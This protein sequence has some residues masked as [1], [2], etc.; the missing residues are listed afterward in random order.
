MK[1]NS[2]PNDIKALILIEVA[3]GKVKEVIAALSKLEDIKS[4]YRVTGPYD[5]IVMVE[6]KDLRALGELVT[7]QIHSISGITKTMTCLVM[8]IGGRAIGE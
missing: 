6:C 7:E 5:V 1:A 3:V 2:S 8:A 4:V